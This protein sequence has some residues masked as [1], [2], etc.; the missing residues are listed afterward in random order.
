MM[1]YA[2]ILAGG[3]GSR[4]TGSRMP[5]QFLEIERKP[6]LIHTI[7]AFLHCEEIIHIAVAAAKGWLN[8]TE[9]ILNDAFGDNPRL[10]VTLGGTDRLGSLQNA[11]IFLGDRFGINPEDIV[12]TQDGARPFVTP[13]IIKDNIRL[14]SKYDAVTTAYPVVDTILCSEDGVV[15]KDIPLRKQMYSVQTPQTFRLGELL[16]ALGELPPEE[17][18]FITDGAKIYLDRGKSVGIAMGS[19]EN[20]KVT[21]PKDLAVA[22]FIL[23]N[24]GV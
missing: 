12:L 9:D 21:E 2:A 18:K 7:T 10:S 23:Q 15:V 14:M 1:I 20:I 16:T 3:T 13:A 17:K 4:M 5:K 22:K 8:E 11:C 6:L 19:A 24:K